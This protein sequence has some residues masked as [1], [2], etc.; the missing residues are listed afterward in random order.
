VA[1]SKKFGCIFV[2]IASCLVGLLGADRARADWE[3]Y[4]SADFGI[5]TSDADTDGRY[6]SGTASFNLKG[7][8]E[9]SSPLVGGAV[10]LEIP[11]D[12]ILPR[13][14]LL[15]VR[16][17]DWPM[18]FE[19]EGAGL[20]EYEFNTVGLGGDRFYSEV[21]VSTFFINTW[22]D[23]PMISAYQ[24]IQYLFGL[25]RQPRVRQVLEPMSFYLG[26]GVGFSVLEFK[27][28]DNSLRI[29]DDFI[30][31]AWNV[32][33]GINYDLTDRVSLG[34]GYRYVGVGEQDLDLLT[35]GL[36]ADP[37]AEMK[38]DQDIHEFRATIR[39]MIYDFLSPWR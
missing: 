6:E 33:T 9:D 24:P 36:P 32:G 27:G 7:V 22:L 18:R 16:L 14:W 8:D 3:V 25:G 11:M 1:G 38:F 12:E 28:T 19:M 2:F 34:A 5:S 15:D 26:W 4:G 31:F 37:N 29:S 30:D 20:R 39:V 23:I 13:E 35:G 17:P 21:D 10:G